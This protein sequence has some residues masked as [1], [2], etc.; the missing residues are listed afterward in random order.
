MSNARD[1]SAAAPDDDALDQLRVPVGWTALDSGG[2]LLVIQ[3]RASVQIEAS[4]S[5]PALRMA[6]RIDGSLGRGH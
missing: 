5:K 1:R 3:G 4:H 6:G 2:Y